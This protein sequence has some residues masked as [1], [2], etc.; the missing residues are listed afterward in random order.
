M[1]AAHES[2][3]RLFRRWMA[4]VADRDLWRHRIPLPASALE[5]VEATKASNRSVGVQ[6]GHPAGFTDYFSVRSKKSIS[7]SA[8]RERWS[9]VRSRDRRPGR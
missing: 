3:G 7:A 1:T 6:F 2:S 5:P 9:S 4:C 8:T